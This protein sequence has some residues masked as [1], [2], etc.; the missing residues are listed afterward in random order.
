[1]SDMRTSR[2]SIMIT[3]PTSGHE[4]ADRVEHARAEEL[5]HGV[6][7]VGGAR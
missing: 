6:H 3:M 2:R 7:V 4:I 1:M 5:A